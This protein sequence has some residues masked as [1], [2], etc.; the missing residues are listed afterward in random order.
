MSNQ[1]MVGGTNE[2]KTEETQNP[3]RTKGR[4][5]KADPAVYP[6]ND[7]D[8]LLVFG[9]FVTGE[10]GKSQMLVYPSYKNLAE[11]FG[12]SRALIATYA[13]QH[14]CLRRR[15]QAQGRIQAQTDQKLVEL[16]ATAAAFSKDDAIRLID[17][18]LAGFEKALADG[19]VR[20]DNPSDLNTMLRLKEFL[21]GGADSRQEVHAS[22]SLAD[23]QARHLAM[24]R[25]V[26][27]ATPAIRGELP[28][29]TRGKPV[30]GVVEQSEEPGPAS[31][32]PG[33]EIP[34]R[35][36]PTERAEK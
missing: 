14:N 33:G 19:R 7:L 21:M 36:A 1:R 26:N 8:R 5:P 3:T 16:R 31:T 2:M 20:F 9:E 13:K 17:T 18:Y 34:P 27:E 10:D 22:L 15:E 24:L 30:D 12:V 25:A 28:T 35:I 6:A 4:P 32:S 29:Q 11:R 23:I